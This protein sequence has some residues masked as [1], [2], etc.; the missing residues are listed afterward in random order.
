MLKRTILSAQLSAETE[1]IRTFFTI[2][3]GNE[4]RNAANKIEKQNAYNRPPRYPAN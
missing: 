3:T 1:K 2:F 4:I